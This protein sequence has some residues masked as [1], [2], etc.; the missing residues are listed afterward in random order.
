[1]SQ[2]SLIGWQLAWIEI[3]SGFWDGN[4]LRLS[5]FSPR[6]MWFYTRDYLVLCPLSYSRF[7]GAL[8]VDTVQSGW[9]WDGAALAWTDTNNSTTIETIL[10]F[11]WRLSAHHHMQS[12][13]KN[14]IERSITSKQQSIS[15]NDDLWR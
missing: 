8:L 12:S 10:S 13:S 2:G 15:V 6:A 7:G 3:S 1:M 14:A 11:G 5:S 9:C 4:L